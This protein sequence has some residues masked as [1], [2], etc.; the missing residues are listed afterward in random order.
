MPLP[1]KRIIR[2]APPPARPNAEINPGIFS[3]PICSTTIRLNDARGGALR[4]PTIRFWPS[5]IVAAS[6]A[7]APHTPHQQGGENSEVEQCISHIGTRLPKKMQA[8]ESCCGIDQTMQALP[9]AAQTACADR[10][11]PPRAGYVASAAARIKSLRF[12]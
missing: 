10:E 8:H 6:Q 3:Q 4:H 7:T 5:P 11:T 9:I 1:G 12:R 2:I